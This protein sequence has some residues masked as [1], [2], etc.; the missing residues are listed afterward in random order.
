MNAP[1]IRL[2][3]S[4]VYF[5]SNDINIELILVAV[6]C[7][8]SAFALSDKNYAFQTSKPLVEIFKASE[9]VSATVRF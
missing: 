9:G 8:E 6:Q 5:S 7:L 1:T 2:K 4:K 3:Q